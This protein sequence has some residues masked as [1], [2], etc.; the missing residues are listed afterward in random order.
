GS[1]TDLSTKGLIIGGDAA[2]ASLLS[3]EITRSFVLREAARVYLPPI[4]PGMRTYAAAINDRGSVVGWADPQFHLPP[5][6]FTI[7]DSNR[8]AIWRPNG[9][10][11]AA[12]MLTGLPNLESQAFAVNRREQ[13]LVEVFDAPDVRSFIWRNGQTTEFR[14]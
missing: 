3:A 13:I 9:S 1:V 8:A 12:E 5:L 14:D 2:P 10:S 6:D 7:Y 11:Y 4:Q